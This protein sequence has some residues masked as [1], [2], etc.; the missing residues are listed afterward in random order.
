[1]VARHRDGCIIIASSSKRHAALTVT[2]GPYADPAPTRNSRGQAKPEDRA[3][4]SVKCQWGM[5]IYITNMQNIISEPCTILHI[6]FWGVH[7]ILHIDAY[8]DICK[9]I[10]LSVL[11]SH[12]NRACIGLFK[13]L[14]SKSEKR[15]VRT[16]WLQASR[17]SCE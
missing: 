14:L 11:K 4:T 3:R 7:I 15:F 6:D 1:M 17:R 16:H 8:Y 12:F 9:K 2:V 10:V 5:H 13:K